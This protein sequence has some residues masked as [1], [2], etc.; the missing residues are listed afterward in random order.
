MPALTP[1]FGV[2]SRSDTPHFGGTVALR[3]VS[4]LRGDPRGRFGNLQHTALSAFWFGT[5]F[6]LIPLTTILIQAQVDEVVPRGRRT[7]PS[8]WLWPSAACWR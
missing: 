6:L 4:G 8:A 1:A 3:H 2:Q 7:P 5:N